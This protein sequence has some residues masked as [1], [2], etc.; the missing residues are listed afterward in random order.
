MIAQS[1]DCVMV[2]MA[3]SE[4]LLGVC[5]A[6][7]HSCPVSALIWVH[8]ECGGLHLYLRARLAE[9]YPLSVECG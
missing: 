5:S 4:C 7:L 9:D 3:E 2:V 6:L 8:T 1:S